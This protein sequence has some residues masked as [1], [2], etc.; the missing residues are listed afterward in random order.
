MPSGFS[1]Y[2]PLRD[3]FE[4]P[5]ELGRQMLSK[6]SEWTSVWSYPERGEDIDIRILRNI[7]E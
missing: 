7:Q 1:N 4:D 5:D 6:Y 3:P 2:L